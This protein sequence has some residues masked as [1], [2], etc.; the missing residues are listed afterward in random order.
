MAMQHRD[1]PQPYQKTT[2]MTEEGGRVANR[3]MNRRAK[4]QAQRFLLIARQAARFDVVCCGSEMILKK[5]LIE[6][7]LIESFNCE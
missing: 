5:I 6:Q 2:G 4:K 3:R 1:G 7:S